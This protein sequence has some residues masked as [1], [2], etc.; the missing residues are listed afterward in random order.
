MKKVNY[1][2]YTYELSDEFMCDI[3]KAD[4]LG[5]EC[6]EAWIYRTTYGVK[7]M[8]FGVPVKQDSLEEVLDMVDSLWEEYAEGYDEMY[9]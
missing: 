5:D 4:R 8:M 1:K 7:D 2:T 6:Y 3:V 9:S